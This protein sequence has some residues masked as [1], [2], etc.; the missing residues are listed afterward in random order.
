MEAGLKLKPFKCELL[1]T[2]VL[3][4]GHI[5]GKDGVGLH[6][7]PKLIEAIAEWGTPE[8]VKQVQQFLGLCNYHRWFIHQFSSIASPLTQLTKKDTEYKWT[9]KCEDAFC[10]LKKLLCEAPVLG[11]PEPE[12]KYVLDTGASDV[13]IG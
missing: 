13:G 9:E 1:K 4:L 11:Y 3:F 7:N 8:N 6:P 12:G 10:R 5:V 2:E